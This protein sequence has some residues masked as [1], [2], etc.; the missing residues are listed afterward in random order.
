MAL[1]SLPPGGTQG[2]FPVSSHL[3]PQSQSMYS[4]ALL[5]L[6]LLLKILEFYCQS[7]PLNS[8]FVILFLPDFLFVCFLVGGSA[9]LCCAVFCFTFISLVP[10]LPAPAGLI[11]IPWGS[12]T[13]QQHS[14]L[15]LWGSRKMTQGGSQIG[16]RP[17]SRATA[18]LTVPASHFTVYKNLP[19]SSCYRVLST[20]KD[21]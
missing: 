2:Q 21:V 13:T 17:N 3:S 1:S 9:L 20:L 8:I 11:Q 19:P 16:D 18:T 15:Y 10:W 6:F 14:S 7:S 12:V 4:S 5:A